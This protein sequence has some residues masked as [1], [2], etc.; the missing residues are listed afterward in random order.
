MHIIGLGTAAPEQRYTQQQCLQALASSD[1]YRKLSLRSQTLLKK[2][3]GNGSS[4][5][6]ARHLVLDPLNEFVHFNPDALY[7][8]FLKHA[9]ALATRAAACALADAGVTADQIDA[10][11]IST[12]TGY[13]CPGLSSYVVE[14]LP[15]KHDVHALDLVGHG[16][17]AALPTLQTAE[18]LLSANNRYHT[19]LSI[20]VEICTAAFYLDDDPGVLISACLFGDGAAA[21]VL[22]KN[23][24][25]GRRSVSWESSHSVIVPEQRDQLRFEQRHGMLRNILTPPVPQIAAQYADEILSCALAEHG[26]RQEDIGVWIWHTGGRDVLNALAQ[27]MHLTE[28]DLHWS[29]EVL[30]EY[31]NMS[32]PSVLFVLQRALNNAAPSGWWWLS[33]FGAGFSSHGALLKVGNHS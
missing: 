28:D 21:A 32:S 24:V 3:L 20:C 16:C 5:I 10:V 14:R 11:I 7:Q 13:L 25:P 12:C 4:G 22:R 19:V 8:R 29:R 2:V 1:L 9:P 31:G 17:G 18:T 26:L 23:P 33:A 15:L 30:K 6:I 27:Q